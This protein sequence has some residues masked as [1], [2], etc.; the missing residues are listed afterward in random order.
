M[1]STVYLKSWKSFTIA[2]KRSTIAFCLIRSSDSYLWRV[3]MSSAISALTGS[4]CSLRRPSIIP[5]PFEYSSPLSLTCCY[6][7]ISW[8]SITLTRP[9]ILSL[10]CY[11]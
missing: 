5:I 11:L 4:M 7:R 6:R 2:L 10:T 9:S 1:K 3:F 8:S